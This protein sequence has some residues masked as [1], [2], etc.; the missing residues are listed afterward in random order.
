MQY[1]RRTQIKAIPIAFRKTD[2]RL[3]VIEMFVAIMLFAVFLATRSVPIQKFPSVKEGSFAG[4]SDSHTPPV[5]SVERADRLPISPF[6]LFLFVFSFG[7]FHA[8]FFYLEFA[9]NCSGSLTTYDGCGRECK[10]R[11]GTLENCHR[12]RKEFTSMTKAERIRFIE[13]LKRL[14]GDLQFQLEHSGLVNIHREYFLSGLHEKENFLPWHRFYL[15]RFENLLRRV[16]CR[17]TIPYWDWAR[18]AQSFWRSAHIRDIWHPGPH[19]LGGDGAR[20]TGCVRDGPFKQ[21]SWFIASQARFGCLT[22]RFVKNISPKDTSYILDTLHSNFDTFESRMRDVLHAEIHC[23]IGGTMCT[24]SSSQAPEFWLHHSFLDKLWA[25]F[26]ARS[27]G[28][29]YAY[30]PA[31]S[32]ELPGFSKRPPDLIDN[33]NLPGNVKIVYRSPVPYSQPLGTN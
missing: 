24:N 15:L 9:G 29:K 22:R 26:Q 25:E 20:E 32:M 1:P 7:H 14:A 30:F 18:A 23:L 4:L 11:D 16:D 13:T 17:V 10:C 12:V 6:P 27:P 5:D 3:P 28:H 33:E 31:L 21:G 8:Y 19:G 2:I